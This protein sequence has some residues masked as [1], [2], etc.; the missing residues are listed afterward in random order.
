MPT[1]HTPAVSGLTY[2]PMAGLTKS[3]VSSRPLSPTAPDRSSYISRD[4][5]AKSR[6][7]PAWPTRVVR[8]SDDAR[9]RPPRST[10]PIVGQG[11]HTISKAGLR[12]PLGHV[13]AL[14]FRCGGGRHT[15]PTPGPNEPRW[16][17]P[18]PGWIDSRPSGPP[19]FPCTRVGWTHHWTASVSSSLAAVV[20]SP[21]E[22]A[23]T[24]VRIHPRPS[25]AS[26][27]A[28]SRPSADGCR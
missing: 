2:P 17:W 28:I 22:G 21:A 27:P 9:E 16:S 25:G 1:P 12:H 5:Q 11:R 10:T 26:G 19:A 14:R 15:W 7:R 3:F 23:D 6:A 8:H 4:G 18:M 20:T 13:A 24:E